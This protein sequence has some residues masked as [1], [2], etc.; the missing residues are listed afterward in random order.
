MSTNAQWSMNPSINTPICT[1]TGKQ[2]DMR[3]MEDGK[4]GAFITW[5][6][7]RTTTNIPDIYIQR[8]NAKGIAL[9]TNNGIALCTDSADQSTPNITTDMKGGAIV[10][11]S[12]WRSYIERDIYA[13]R[14]DSNGQILWTINGANVTDSSAREHSEK[15]IS[16]GH[17]GIIIIFEKQVYTTT[18]HWEIWAQRLDSSGT[19]K[20]GKGGVSLS[21]SNTN[22]RNHK[23]QKDR[24]GGAFIVWQ[25]LNI[26]GNYDVYGQ[27]INANGILLWGN[28]GK[29]ICNA[30][31]D[32]I[33]AKIDPDSINNGA[34]IAWQDTRN[35]TDYDIYIQRVDS[36]G[37][38]IWNTNGVVVSNANNNQ[39][40]LDLMSISTTNETIITWKDNRNGDYDIYA[41]KLNS[42]G[43]A[44]WTANGKV[45]CNSLK[46]Q[47]NPNI[48]TDENKGAIIVW[49]DSS[50]GDWNVMAQKID[51]NGVIQ[52]ANN[53]EIV[54]NATNEQSSPKNVTDGKGG[55]IFAWQDKRS[56][57]FDIYT[58]HLFSSG[59]PNAIQD[60][61]KIVSTNLYPNPCRNQFL[62]SYTLA[63][64]DYVRIQLLD[65]TGQMMQVLDDG[66]KQEHAGEHHI[67]CNVHALPVGLYTVEIKNNNFHKAIQLLKMN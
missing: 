62:L 34:F 42:N 65:I 15:I 10:A 59:S 60:N 25:D 5:K 23:V 28:N 44:Q 45:I 19:K 53:G 27:H 7:Y 57:T 66:S 61:L 21:L 33:N 29:A 56:G 31:G 14:V 64:S 55:S 26:A 20:W 38:S 6:D 35:S 37:N 1:A 4:G 30:T 3:M 67:T 2:I 48:C 8:V 49:Q 46:D 52:W 54:S 11:W 50:A 22:K 24:N 39:S 51:N 43:I 36:N 63:T 47:I 9:W 13:Q 18:S 12:D 41:Q 17:G 58:H 16:D 40:A 32:Q